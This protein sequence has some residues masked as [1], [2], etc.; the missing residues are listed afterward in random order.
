[1]NLYV[2]SE[3]AFEYRRTAHAAIFGAWAP[4]A[5]TNADLSFSTRK[6]AE[7]APEQLRDSA[8]LDTATGIVAAD[9]AVSVE[10]ARHRLI[11]AADRAGIPVTKLAEIVVALRDS[12]T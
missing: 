9:Q 8:V 7:R 4:G 5:V 12:N 3:D 11:D 1:M 6:L 10:A 2:R